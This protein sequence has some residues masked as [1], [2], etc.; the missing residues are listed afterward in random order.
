MDRQVRC[1]TCISRV[2]CTAPRGV[3]ISEAATLAVR[4][5]IQSM[6]VGRGLTIYLV[7]DPLETGTLQSLADPCTLVVSKFVCRD[8]GYFSSF[9]WPHEN[10]P[11]LFTLPTM[12]LYGRRRGNGRAEEL[13]DVCLPLSFRDM[14]KE[15]KFFSTVQL[16]SCIS[17][18][19]L[20]TT[21]I[22]RSGPH[23]NGARSYCTLDS[24]RS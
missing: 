19:Q 23:L 17:D 15:R 11:F 18:R 9:F 4:A 10:A 13:M 8:C 16:C 22:A 21:S 24:S 6:N 1:A 3:L 20:H 12:S 2:H 5:S 7:S 14:W